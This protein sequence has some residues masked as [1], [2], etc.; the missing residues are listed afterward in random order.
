MTV[1]STDG[2]QRQVG[3]VSTWRIWVFR[4]LAALAGCIFLVTL[5]QAISPWGAV[6]LSN[7]NGVH[8][9]NLHRWSRATS[10]GPLLRSVPC[11]TRPLEWYKVKASLR[12]PHIRIELDGHVLISYT[13]DFSRR[14]PV[15]LRFWN[16]AG[17]FRNIKVSAPDGTVLWEGPPDL[18]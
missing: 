16:G 7:T 10:G 13:D 3:A 6:T 4:V 12:G 11:A 9:L 5:P 18:P 8:D 1:R 15:G 2:S 17:R 14:G